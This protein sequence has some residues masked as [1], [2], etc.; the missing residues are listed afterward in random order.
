MAGLTIYTATVE[1]TREWGILKA[2]GFRN[3][4]LYRVVMLQSIA[5]GILGFTVGAGLAT[6]VGPFAADAAPQLVLLVTVP[7]LLAIAAV[8]LLMAVFA[9]FIPIRRLGNI[10]PAHV[11]KS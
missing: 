1:K 10:D 7:D 5:T 3:S 4:F 11:F 8:T 2:V 9:A 6:L